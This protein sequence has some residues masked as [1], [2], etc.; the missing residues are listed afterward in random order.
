MKAL[1]YVRCS[2]ISQ[3]EE[4]VSLDNQKARIESYCRYKG[5]EL[6]GIIED[7]G[8]SGGK[9]KARPGF[10]EVLD[11]IESGEVE[12]LILYSLERLSRDML[13]LF[14][15]D[16]LLNEQDIELHTVEGTVD[17]STPDG[18]MNFAMKAFLGEMERRQIKYRTR[19][20]LQFKKAQGF[21]VG[22][23]PYGFRRIQD[24]LEPDEAEQSTIALAKSL[25][26]AS[27]GLSAICRTLT[28]Q[29]RLTRN[30]KV[31]TVEQVKRILPDYEK[32][33][34]HAN[35]KLSQNIRG[36]IEAIA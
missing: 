8:I 10:I 19:K 23:A 14:A 7:A 29:G 22:S 34:S 13:T 4:G 25:Y 24:R 9:N 3:A 16:R 27:Y 5:F 30:G 2:T 21:I 31:F 1:G 36:F 15:L 6:V 35:T 18:W 33:F 12:A 11:R 32:T 17:T 26:G 28:E 20:A